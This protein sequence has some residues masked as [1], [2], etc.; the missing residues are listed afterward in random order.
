MASAVQ[1]AKNVSA[2]ELTAIIGV[3]LLETL[4]IPKTS[5][6]SLYIQNDR[7]ERSQVEKSEAR[8]YLQPARYYASYNRGVMPILPANTVPNIGILLTYYC[9]G[10]LWK[11]WWNSK[12]GISLTVGTLLVY[13][14][15]STNYY[16][17]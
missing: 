10:I 3:S 1:R 2:S 9:R 6:N 16:Y 17:W 11:Y 4:F 13:Y 8:Q 5:M 7:E 12:V 14:G 15:R